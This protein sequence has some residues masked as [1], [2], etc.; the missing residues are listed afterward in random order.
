VLFSNCAGAV[1]LGRQGL[2]IS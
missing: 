2:A 1:V